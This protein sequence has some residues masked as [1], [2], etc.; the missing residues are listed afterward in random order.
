MKLRLKNVGKIKEADIKFDGITVIAGEN[1]TGKSTVGKILFCIYHSFYRMEEQIKLEREKTIARTIDNFYREVTNRY[2][3]R[4]NSVRIAQYIIDCRETFLADTRT[5]EKVLEEFFMGEDKT[6]LRKIDGERLEILAEKIYNFLNIPDDEIRKNILHKRLDE[7]FGM[8]VGHVNDL[9][10]TAQIELLIKGNE[11]KFEIIKNEEISIEKHLSLVKEI[12][13]IDDPFVLDDLQKSMRVPFLTYSTFGHRGD[14]IDKIIDNEKEAE[15]SV[16]EELLAKKKL[17]K[18][19]EAMDDVC[20][21][22]LVSADDRRNYVYKSVKLNDELEISNL[23]T[24]L[25]SFVILRTLLQNGR[26]DENGIIILDEPEI[27]LHP[28]WQLRFAEIIVLIHKEFGTNIL[29]NTHSPYFLNAIEVFAE[30]YEIESKCNYYLTE[31][32]GERTKI[33]D[34]TEERELI[35]E[36]LARPLQDLENMRYRY[37]DT[38]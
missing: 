3:L 24:G 17:Q 12:I 16:V 1:N 21:G 36:K 37:G 29:L 34:A 8:K 22:T 2:T 38:V 28:E 35:Y 26:I 23:S 18:I 4:F 31:E 20:E 14:L 25:K 19:Y 10:N 6:F 7:E 9:S 5:I 15:F 27:H 32:V 33:V 13:Y 11:I 30:K